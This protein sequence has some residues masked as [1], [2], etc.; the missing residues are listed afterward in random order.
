MVS[1]TAGGPKKVTFALLPLN[2]VR[3]RIAD[4]RECAENYTRAQYQDYYQRVEQK[5]NEEIAVLL[6]DLERFDKGI[7]EHLRARLLEF[8][9][10]QL[11]RGAQGRQMVI[12][13]KQTE[14]P[15]KKGQRT[16]LENQIKMHQHRMQERRLE[17]E[18][19][20]LGA[21]PAPELLNMVIV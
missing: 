4:L 7:M 13:M 20:R 15:S 19:M 6:D 2:L 18:N 14:D 10:V 11:S 1:A 3:E 5:R 9:S 8:T 17:V 21:F 16:R 12:G